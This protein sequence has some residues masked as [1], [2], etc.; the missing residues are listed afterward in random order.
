MISLKVTCWRTFIPRDQTQWRTSVS[1]TLCQSTIY[2]GIEEDGARKYKL[3]NKPRLP[4]HKIFNPEKEDQ[5]EA[6]Y[7][8]LVLLFVPFRD[9][10]ETEV[11]GNVS[12]FILGTTECEKEDRWTKLSDH[13]FQLTLSFEPVPFGS[14]HRLKRKTTKQ[15]R[16][17]SSNYSQT[18][19]RL[20]MKSFTRLCKHRQW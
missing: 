20:T 5:K 10:S 9:E 7:Y 2:A 1:M 11:V 6:Y 15:P 14:S 12:C 13:G 16:K 4:N 18:T 17:P 3:L 19:S 8:S